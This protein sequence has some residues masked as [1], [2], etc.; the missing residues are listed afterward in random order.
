MITKIEIHNYESHKRTILNFPTPGLTVFI[1]ESDR[2]KSGAFRAF[3]FAR[4]NTP[5]GKDMLPLFW[6]GET[7]VKVFFDTG[8]EVQRIKSG[9]VNKYVLIEG[10]SKKEFNAGRDVPEE[11]STVFNMEETNFQSQIDRAFLMFDTSGQRGRILN[12]IVG[13]DSIDNTLSAAK[14][15]V[16]SLNQEKGNQKNIIESLETKLEKYVN[17]PTVNELLNQCEEAERMIQNLNS[18]I[19]GVTKVQKQLERK[20][21]EIEKYKNLPEIKNRF[22]KAETTSNSFD[23]IKRD[24]SNVS[25]IFNE[26]ERKKELSKKGKGLVKVEKLI[27]RIKEKQILFQTVDSEYTAVYEIK[28]KI[29]AC[30]NKREYLKKQIEAEKLNIP[31]NCPTCGKQIDEI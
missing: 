30:L 14:R 19:S 6:E 15:D 13:L 24:I 29:Q 9:S 27:D 12:K 20:K 3:N 1:G 16:Q 5:L 25:T 22:L 7:K 11:I 31:K 28:R 26:L 17:L 21:I 18:V 23:N 10:E 8:E 2:G 4:T